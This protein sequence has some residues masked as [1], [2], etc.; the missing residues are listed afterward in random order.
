MAYPSEAFVAGYAAGLTQLVARRLVSDLDTP[1]SAFLKLAGA[2]PYAFLL[3]SVEGGDQLG[4]YSIIGLEPDAVWRWNGAG[5]EVNRAF[6]IDPEAFAAAPAAPLESLKAF[7]DESRAAPPLGEPPL[8][9]MSSGVFGFLGYAVARATERLPDPPPAFADLPDAVM[10]RPTLVAVFDNVRQEISIATPVRPVAGVAAAEAYLAATAKLDAA[11]ARL[12]AAPAETPHP[13]RAAMPT[14]ALSPTSSMSHEAYESAVDAAKERI[15]AGDIFQVVLSQRFE[16]PFAGSPFSL[17]RALR[18]TNPSPFLF[19]LNFGAFA[20]VGSSPEILVRV[21]DGDVTIRP[22]AGT[23][24]RGRDADEDAALADDL[25]ADEKER[26]EH[27]MLL[28]LGRNDVGRS[29]KVGTV[30]VTDSFAIERY[31]HVM[32]IVSNVV[33]ALKDG[34]H[35]VDAVANGFPAGTVTGAPKIRAMEIIN[36]LEVAA[37]GP[38]GG[39]IGYFSADGTVDTCITLRTGLVMDGKLIVQAGA[40]IVADS[41]PAKEQAECENK[42]RA[43]FAAA[44]AAL[45]LDSGT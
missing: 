20:L 11:E 41:D 26:A 38:Y 30:R 34:A 9:P 32:H 19:Y 13:R 2:R 1:V 40:G 3:E 15:F 10:M 43:L 37:R 27:L 21:R 23:R 12:A 33:G 24:P 18:R 29:A 16:A 5:A 39:A 7:I 6:Q 8:P 35:P 44:E 31:S 36:E 28:D 4:R 17:Y 45:A 25:L 42:A 22:I 14:T